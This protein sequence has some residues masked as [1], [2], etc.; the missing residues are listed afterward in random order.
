M[1]ARTAPIVP[2]TMAPT[3]GDELDDWVGTADAVDEGMTWVLR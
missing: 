3:L 2:P 1:A